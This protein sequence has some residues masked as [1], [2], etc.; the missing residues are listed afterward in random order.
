MKPTNNSALCAMMLLIGAHVALPLSAQNFAGSDDFSSVTGLWGRDVTSGS[1]SFTVANGVLNFTTP[2][3][4]PNEQA[5]RFWILNNGSY[6][7]DWSLSMDVTLGTFAMSSGQFA[8]AGMYVQNQGHVSQDFVR[9]V[10]RRDSESSR[11]FYA[12]AFANGVS[13]GSVFIPTTATAVSLGLSYDATTHTILAAYDADG[14]ANGYLFTPFTT[15]DI[16][17]AGTDWHMTPSD[18]FGARIFGQTTLPVSMGQVTI[19]NFTAAPLTLQVVP[20]PS[21]LILLG[22]GIG[23]YLI[24]RRVR[25]TPPNHALQRTRPSPRGCNSHVSRAG[26]LSLGR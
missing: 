25:K 24:I 8:S 14:A 6:T 17:A 18:V 15:A 22:V 16:D 19:D 1:G 20:E 13:L 7:A 12:D 4:S 26:S 2:S 23:V 21:S 9:V 3:F 10:L 5:A 11:N